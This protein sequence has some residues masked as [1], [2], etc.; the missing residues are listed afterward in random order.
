MSLMKLFLERSHSITIIFSTFFIYSC[1]SSNEFKKTETPVL[2]DGSNCQLPKK[3][4]EWSKTTPPRLIWLSLDSL[5]LAG[6]QEIVPLLQNPHPKGLKWILEA[7]NQNQ[8]LT[9]EE[10]TITASSHISTMTCST[11]GIHGVFANSQWTGKGTSSGFSMPFGIETFATALKNSGLKVV[12]GAYPALDNS[13]PGRSVDEGFAYGTSVGRGQVFELKK[14]K[15]IIHTWKDAHGQV[16]ET[17]KIKDGEGQAPDKFSCEKHFCQ[18][19]KSVVPEMLD[20]TFSSEKQIFRS[21]AQFIPGKINQLFIS[22]LSLNNSFPK[23]VKSKQES[24]GLI[25]SPGKEN[26]LSQFGATPMIRGLQ[27]RLAFF[28]A[29]WERYLPSTEAD[30]IF[31]YLEDIDSLRHQFSGDHGAK[32]AVALHYERVD[33]VVGKLFAS[34]SESVNVIVLGDHGMSTIK[35]ELNIRKIIPE[36]TLRRSNLITSGGTLLLYGSE[37]QSL[38][39]STMPSKTEMDWLNE[40]KTTLLQFKTKP[41]GEKIFN[42]VFVKGTEEM[43]KAGLAHKNAPFLIAFTNE[44]FSLQ[45]S[46]SNEVILADRDNEKLP[47]PRPR[48][49]HGH[50]KES[51]RMKSFLAGWG[52]VVD[53][54]KLNTIHSNIDLVPTLGK[55]FAWPVP[56]Q[57]RSIMP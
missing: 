49:Q 22:P 52:P 38:D 21:Y 9:I 35:K 39:P 45:N 19:Q 44:D 13:E 55:A 42:K 6:L 18:V 30:V 56:S 1:A 40:T 33:Q 12:T 10:P 26:S 28:D 15:D 4:Y 36:E 51:S 46:M 32:S 31:L 41:W 43:S 37:S 23:V 54:I 7:K 50:A 24:C 11:A 29:N 34:L 53:K 27:H 5:N 57:C 2:T 14:G 8:R 47:P 20:I 17:L 25:F 48:G 3:P 16:I